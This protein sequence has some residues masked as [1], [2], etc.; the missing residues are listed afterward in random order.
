MLLRWKAYQSLFY[1]LKPHIW[2]DERFV[3]LYVYYDVIIISDFQHQSSPPTH[4]LLA[5]PDHKPVSWVFRLY[6]PTVC[7]GSVFAG[8]FKTAH[9]FPLRSSLTSLFAMRYSLAL[10]K[11]NLNCR[12]GGSQGRS[13]E[14]RGSSSHETKRA[15]RS[16]RGTNCRHEARGQSRMMG[17]LD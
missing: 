2:N 3:S 13:C 4:R 7:Q 16:R 5:K 14:C 9:C 12:R 6:P 11:P 10:D 17:L 1:H 15:R 8:L